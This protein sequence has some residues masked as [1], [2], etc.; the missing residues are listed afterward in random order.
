M[1][2]SG[3]CVC[4]CVC[5]RERERERDSQVTSYMGKDDLFRCVGQRLTG[6]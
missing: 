4:V 5:V 6:N 3:V 1:T 2:S